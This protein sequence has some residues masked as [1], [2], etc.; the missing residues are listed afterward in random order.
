M[1]LNLRIYKIQLEI[2]FVLLD[3]DEWYDFKS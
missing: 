3:I 1:I 2:D